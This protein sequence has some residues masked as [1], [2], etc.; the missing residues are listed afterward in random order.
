MEVRAQRVCGER[1]E[2][3]RDAL[4]VV[5]GRRTRGRGRRREIR[6]NDCCD[7]TCWADVGYASEVMAS[8]PAERNVPTEQRR[9]DV[10]RLAKRVIA[11]DGLE[12]A[13]LRQIA[14]EGDFTT[15]VLSHHFADRRA[16][17][18]ACFEHSM[19]EWL[20]LT[21]AL[22]EE[23]PTGSA[24]LHVFLR[25]AVPTGGEDADGWRVWFQMCGYAMRDPA[26]ATTLAETD[27]RWDWLIARSLRRWQQEGLLRA[28]VQVRPTAGI[29]LALVNGLCLSALVDGR[30]NHARER[31][32]DALEPLGLPAAVGAAALATA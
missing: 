15:G 24:D 29:L 13:S 25:T 12:G 32:V 2:V 5:A 1:V 11:R 10:L 17:V 3:R 27:R 31:L 4:G 18:V 23:A 8:D 30:W 9:D 6:H 19:R 22:L 16:L 7:Y 20:D 28:D 21:A 26:A 14:R